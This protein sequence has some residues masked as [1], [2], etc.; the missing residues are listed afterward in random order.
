MLLDIDFFQIYSEK[1]KASHTK[2]ELFI[3]THQIIASYG[4]LHL[5]NT[6]LRK[7]VNKE[8]LYFTSN[9]LYKFTFCLHIIVFF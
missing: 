2:L 1:I 5:N 9:S 6:M 3:E 7:C 4:N 8:N